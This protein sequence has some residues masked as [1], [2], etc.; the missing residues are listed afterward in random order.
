MPCFPEFLSSLTSNLNRRHSMHLFNLL[1]KFCTKLWRFEA[2]NYF[3]SIIWFR[4]FFSNQKK[5]IVKKN[6]S[7]M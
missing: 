6:K 5:R 4:F 7:I 3:Y 1:F 2:A